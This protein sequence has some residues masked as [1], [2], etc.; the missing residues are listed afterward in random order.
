M[1]HATLLFALAAIPANAAD[2]FQSIRAGNCAEV[3]RLVKSSE[4]ANSRNE[5]SATALMYAALHADTACLKHLLDKGAD[6]N[7]T[8][9]AGATALIW[10]AGDL[11]KVKLLT[12][13][14]ADVQARTKEG[15][16]AIHVA[17][18]Q[19]GTAEI[20][21]LLL[22]KGADA[23]D[24]DQ[25]GATPLLLAA[26]SGDLNTVK[27]LVERGADVQHRASP[28]FGAPRFGTLAP[29]FVSAKPSGEFGGETALTMA[30]A[31]G[32]KDV[33]QYLLSKGAKP[34]LTLVGNFTPLTAAV[35]QAEPEIA[36]MLVA[37]GA[38]VNA[39]E[40][41][42][43]T[44][45]ILA[46]TSD[47]ATPATVQLLLDRGADAS[48]KD[49]AGRTALDWAK[50]RGSSPLTRALGAPSSG[51]ALVAAVAGPTPDPAAVRHA[52]E[53]S[54]SLMLKSSSEFFRQS[55]CIS[56]H[57]QSIGQI[58]VA[59]ARKRGF[60]IDDELAKHQNRATTS[61]FSP[62]RE[63]MLQAVPTVP[64]STIVSTY[65]LIGLAAGV[66]PADDMTDALVHE[67]AARQRHDGSWKG[68]EE[69]P[70]LG[71]SDITGTTLS[72][73]SLKL[74]ALPGRKSEFDR[75]IAKARAWLLAAPTNT[76]QEKTMRLLG[77]AWSKANAS[78]ISAAARDLL[79]AQRVD[80]GWSQLPT[81]E[82]DAYATGLTLFA[83]HEANAITASAPAFQRG[84]S[85][86]LR[87]QKPDGSWHVKSRALGFQPYFESGYPHGHDQWISAA[88]AAW[89][90]TA[91]ALSADQ[92]K[93]VLASR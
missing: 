12:S 62:H 70:P 16:T 29:S 88:G 85:F 14:G 6:A 23:N 92:K 77:L 83:L 51:A 8:N 9:E 21:R 43:A 28:G 36:R 48:A 35:Q 2:F 69:R 15:R 44:P 24:K 72:M 33:V 22:D 59:T 30:V 18:R 13:R 78:A 90:T 11:K 31:A 65:A 19:A 41:R 3:K 27:L 86:L 37:A 68:S 46:A 42:G 79:S 49:A 91:L 89:A 5:K 1:R 50:T 84:I 26:E 47:D 56:C 64:A 20:V 54:L 55:G 32:H 52:V 82:A 66:H 74:Y 67:L 61:V 57:N 87:T 39:R 38:D 58:A 53:R 60:R 10:A 17:A 4:A 63:T 71:Q 45:L 73:R 34:N 25:A 93:T 75:R 40:Y 76:M 7:A 81:L 80:G